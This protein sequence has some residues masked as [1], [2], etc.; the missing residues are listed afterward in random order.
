MFRVTE[1]TKMTPELLAEYI[2]KHKT[3]VTNRYQ[4]LHDAYVNDYEIFHLPKKATYKPDNRISANFAK[5]ITDTMNGFFIGIPIKT[6]NQD[7]KVTE[8]IDFL[9]QYNDQDDNNAELSKLCSIYG[10]AYEMYYNDAE[11]NIGITYLSPMESFMIYDDSILEQPLYFV[12]YY[13]DSENVERGSWSD[14]TIVQHFVQNGSYRWDGE[15]ESH[16]F[17]GV[18]ATEYIENDERVGIFE[19]ALPMI[20][21]YNKAVSEK[22]ND[23]DYFS[24]AYLKVLGQRLDN[25]EIHHIRD[26]RVINFDGDVN[27][28]VVEFLQKP[29]GDET[30]EH[31]LDRLERLIY[32]ISMVAN[33]SD[34]NFGT[35]SGIAMKYKMQAMSNLAK[36]KERKFRSGMQRRYRL[37]FSNP[38][39]TVRGIG[40]DAW[41]SN[42][43]K[44]T[45]N[46]PANLA[47]ETDIASKLEGIVSKETQLSVLSVVENVQDELD[48]IEEEENAQK[49]DARDRVMQMTFGGVNGEQ[50]NVLGHTGNE[51]PDQE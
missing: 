43:Y 8:Y 48:R 26:D 35:S 19:G 46:F 45:L 36:T 38:I 41:I 14:G 4:K 15:A 29:S 44:F 17:D 47:E 27:G 6:T 13:M 37:I 7:D 12:R 32:Q 34:E 23:V 5:Y 9:D 30:Q 25:E 49:D 31:L 11:G 10:K 18:P 39:S 51:E 21:A 50:Q 24:D 33:I 16:Y 3:E 42:D 40:R 2:G 22:A 1:G 20:N 28:V